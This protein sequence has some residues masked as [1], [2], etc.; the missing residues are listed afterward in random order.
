MHRRAEA[1]PESHRRERG[2]V[3]AIRSQT[4]EH[5][6][7]LGVARDLLHSTAYLE[8]RGN[9]TGPVEGWMGLTHTR[10]TA[11]AQLEAADYLSQRLSQ[12]AD[13]LRG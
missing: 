3:L 4:E 11:M 8:G 10:E 6:D 7:E 1:S 5:I 12:A 2:T 9:P 13:T